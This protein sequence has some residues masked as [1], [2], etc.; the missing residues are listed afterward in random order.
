MTTPRFRPKRAA[1]LLEA[2][3]LGTARET[4]GSERRI[5]PIK[6]RALPTPFSRQVKATRSLLFALP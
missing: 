1:A 3:S 6:N 4:C 5:V 2:R